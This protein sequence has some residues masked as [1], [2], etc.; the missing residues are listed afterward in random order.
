M[1]K[2]LSRAQNAEDIGEWQWRD[3][4]DFKRSTPNAAVASSFV[5]S[6]AILAISDTIALKS[7]RGKSYSKST[8]ASIWAK[9]SKQLARN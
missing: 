1:S 5:I 6:V 3:R 8:L 7:N 4:S 2:I 9:I